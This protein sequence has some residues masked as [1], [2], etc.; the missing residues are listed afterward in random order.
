[1]DSAMRGNYNCTFGKTD[2]NCKLFT[3]VNLIGKETDA[4]ISSPET[5]SIHVS[6][7]P[8]FADKK[9]NINIFEIGSC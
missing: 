6:K 7:S 3:Q 5:V 8:G 9:F 2:Q 1:M 4:S